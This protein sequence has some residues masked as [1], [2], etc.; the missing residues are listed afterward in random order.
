MHKTISKHNNS[1]STSKVHGGITESIIEHANRYIASY[2]FVDIALANFVNGL[3]KY[4]PR[5]LAQTT[6]HL[7]S[8]IP[9]HALASY[10]NS[11][12]DRYMG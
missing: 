6:C 1:K 12:S 11:F 8:F 4:L 9:M 3:S 2:C 5:I 7:Y 10:S